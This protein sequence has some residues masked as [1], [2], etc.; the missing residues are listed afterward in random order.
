MQ[1]NC[2]IH[3][4]VNNKKQNFFRTQKPECSGLL[5]PNYNYLKKFSNVERFKVVKTESIDTTT[6]DNEFNSQSSPHFIKIDTE[7]AEVEIISNMKIKPDIILIE[8]H[9]NENRR[10]IEDILSEYILISIQSTG[11]GHGI[12]KYVKQSITSIS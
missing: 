10:L 7:G 6:L 2:A 4:I 11:L 1:P 8:Y 9:S 12:V 3:P 5:E